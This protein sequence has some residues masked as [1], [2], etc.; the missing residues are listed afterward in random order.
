MSQCVIVSMFAL[1]VLGCVRNSTETVPEKAPAPT[2]ETAWA[3]PDLS[4]ASLDEQISFW[5]VARKESPGNKEFLT[6]YARTMR[7]V[8]RSSEAIQSL[9]QED[10]EQLP[11]L[12]RASLF[13]EA[14]EWTRAKDTMREEGLLAVSAHKP[15]ID[16]LFQHVLRGD[17]SKAYDP[18]DDVQLANLILSFTGDRSSG[19]AIQNLQLDRVARIRRIAD[20]QTMQM[21]APKEAAIAT[22]LRAVEDL[23]KPFLDSKL[24]ETPTPSE[25]MA[26]TAPR[27]GRLFRTHCAACHGIQGD[28]KGTASRFLEPQAR[29]FLKEP[30]RYVSGIRSLATDEDLRK[31]IAEGLQGVSMP[32]FSQLPPDEIDALVR[33]VR[34]LQRVGL[35]VAFKRRLQ[36]DETTSAGE[37]S[38]QAWIEARWRDVEALPIP[39]WLTASSIALSSDDTG[40]IKPAQLSAG[41]ELFRK[42]ACLNCHAGHDSGPITSTQFNDAIGRTIIARRF[43]NEPMRRGTDPIELYRR[44]FLGI[45]GTLHPKVLGEL[46]DKETRALI[47]YVIALAKTAPS[48]GTNHNRRYPS[49]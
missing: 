41:A 46:S 38:A 15:A 13:A 24:L 32:G 27:D 39:T 9:T 4:S 25:G 18:T 49:W 21:I 26:D 1:A 10:L 30:M 34:R 33:E 8:G 28:S 31:T 42:F 5:S 44:I 19:G 47:D 36:L 48:S 20:L 22:M 45:P 16:S 29:N 35:E 37:T 43:Q 11:A 3:P 40:E 14:G 17:G 23:Q 12:E 2:P 7:A 6:Q